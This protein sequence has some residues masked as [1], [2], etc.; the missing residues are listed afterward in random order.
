MC[1][2]AQ[3]D[4]K[5]SMIATTST[6]KLTDWGPVRDPITSF[7]TAS[8]SDQ[9]GSFLSAL[10]SP[11]GR[12]L[13]ARVDANVRPAELLGAR[14][15]AGDGRNWTRH[16][17]APCERNRMREVCIWVPSRNFLQRCELHCLGLLKPTGEEV[18]YSRLAPALLSR[19]LRRRKVSKCSMAIRFTGPQ[20]QPTTSDPTT[21]K[22]W[23]EL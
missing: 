4:A 13:A 11:L 7:V 1:S 14:A 18:A 10:R 16:Q 2:M 6:F 21:T 15:S 8:T 17:A 22:A 23:V 20:P 19:G 3:S 9:A 5:E 12:T